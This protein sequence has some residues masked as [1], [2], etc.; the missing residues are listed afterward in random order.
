MRRP[1]ELMR[2]GQAVTMVAARS[3]Q[4]FVLVVSDRIARNADT[5]TARVTGRLWAAQLNF[6]ELVVADPLSIAD[7]TYQHAQRMVDLHREFVHRL[8]EAFDTRDLRGTRPTT[9]NVIQM[10]S[11]LG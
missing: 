4:A 10:Q 9:S 8:F 7:E 6:A 2:R 1:V 11:R 3:S 5:D